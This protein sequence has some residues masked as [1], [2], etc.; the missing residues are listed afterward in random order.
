MLF[1]N[2]VMG[3]KFVLER[4]ILLVKYNQREQKISNEVF[5]LILKESNIEKEELSI[6]EISYI[7]G[8]PRNVL[9]SE[10]SK[11]LILL[12]NNKFPPSEVAT[13]RESHGVRYSNTNKVRY[14][15]LIVMILKICENMVFSTTNSFLNK[16]DW[17][18]F[19]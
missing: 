14:I 6:S 2:K 1:S 17:C 16:E 7:F 9:D 13:T 12:L 3:W 19:Q 15:N 5:D 18:I 8:I 10:K 11:N 4:F